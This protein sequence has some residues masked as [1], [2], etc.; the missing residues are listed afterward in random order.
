MNGR[1]HL[2]LPMWANDAWRGSLY[3]P[4]GATEGHLGDYA[5][6]FSAV[7]GNTTFYSGA[8]K[9]ETVAAWAH[10]VPADFRFCFKLPSNLTHE[11]RLEDI[12]ASF[13]A[14]L[15]ALD[16]LRTRLGPMLVQLP[17]DFGAD[18]LPKLQA[19]L[20]RWPS[21]IP[22]G[23]EVRHSE[24]F[25]KGTAE[26]ELN[27]LLISHGVNRVMLDVRP[28]FSTTAQGHP[29]MIKAQGEKPKRPLHVIST[30]DFPVVRF[31]G[32]ID[33][34]INMHYFQPWIARISLWIK[35]GITPFLFVHTAD[36]RHSPQMAR[37]LYDALAGQIG[38]SPLP[39]F[40]GERQAELF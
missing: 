13:D 29:G 2:G 16:P 25:H 14:F 20:T 31:I 11:R 27:R 36:N 32:H 15:E 6:V 21:D 1:L 24:F 17:R 40:A 8:P 26:T 35:Q 33:A 22:C 9:A 28:L 12:E 39:E 23:V 18:E 3:P 38:L 19:L 5:R 37:R 10:Q 4:H 34:E 7:E 30:G